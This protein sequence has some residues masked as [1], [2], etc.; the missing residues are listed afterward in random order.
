MMT[1]PVVMVPVM[2]MPVMMVPMVVVPMVMM[3]VYLYGLDMIDL[4]LRDDSGLSVDRRSCPQC[5]RYRR[6]RRSLCACGKHH[7]TSHKSHREF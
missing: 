4:I 7:T 6:N 1:V 2:V 3:P 5:T